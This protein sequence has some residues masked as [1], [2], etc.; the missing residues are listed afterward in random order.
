MKQAEIKT[1]LQ[2]L[3][4]DTSENA[5]RAN[6]RTGKF[7]NRFLVYRMLQ[8]MNARQTETERQAEMT[9]ESNGR[10]FNAGDAK[11]LGNI[12]NTSR[13]YNNLTPKQAR[14]AAKRLLKYSRQLEEISAAKTAAA[15]PVA[16]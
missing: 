14:F 16:A 4:D 13:R 11:I 3:I 15:L 9:N 6:E 2:S 7:L 1:L 10:G 8:A 5:D 12:A